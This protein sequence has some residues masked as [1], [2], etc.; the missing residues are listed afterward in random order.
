MN[1]KELLKK[2]N[3]EDKLLI[4][5]ILDKINISKVNNK[6]VYSNFLNPYE[7]KIIKQFLVRIKENNYLFYGGYEN[8]ERKILIIY[9]DKLSTIFEQNI[10]NIDKIIKV[11]RIEL[12]NETKGKYG[13]K[14]YLG[15]IMKLGIKRE[16][17]G[18]IIFDE[19]G[20][21]II[22]ANDILNFIIQEISFLKRFS[23]SKIYEIPLNHIRKNEQQKELI[24]IKVPSMRLDSIVSEIANVSRNKASD[25]ILSEKVFVNY[26]C[27]TKTSKE[28]KVGDIVTIRNKGRFTI[29]DNVGKT[30]KDKK[31]ILI[32]K[33]RK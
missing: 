14:N 33:F 16:M 3:E 29:I 2:Y 15:A 28:I 5:K 12:P 22:I 9:P 19:N 30:K 11:I 23:K 31:I 21:D 20:A 17:V 1:K 26:I 32:E 25:I 4:S 6:I 13:H 18:D 7:E 8:S 10:P 27:E 24:E